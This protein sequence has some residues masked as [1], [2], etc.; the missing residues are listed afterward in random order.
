MQRRINIGFV[1]TTVN[2]G[3]QER[4]LVKIL[5]RLDKERF[6][7]Y[8]YCI[9]QP[10]HLAEDIRS[11]GAELVGP[12]SMCK[13]DLLVPWR[14]AARF[15]HDKI[16]VVN[17][18]G[19]GD[20]MF[21]GRLA[22]KIAGVPVIVAA[23]HST[24]D[25]GRGKVISGPNR[26]LTPITDH[27]IGVGE[28]Q[29]RYLAEH[30]GLPKDRTQVI[31]NGVDHNIFAPSE[32]D[33]MRIRKELN[34]APNAPVIGVVAVMRP[35]KAHGI[36]LKAMQSITA[37]FPD[38]VLFFIGDG[39]ERPNIEKSIDEMGLQRSV[40]LLG[41][42]GD[43]PA[44]L[45][46]LDVA[47]LCSDT[48]AFSNAILEYMAVGKPVVATRVGSVEEMVEEDSTAF[49]IPTQDPDKL[50]EAVIRLL[51]DPDKAREMGRLGRERVINCFSIENMA[52]AREKLFETLLKEKGKLPKSH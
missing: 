4:G 41:L 37:K 11:N 28:K 50:A 34:V 22:G 18:I 19:Q 46:A 8:V 14:L 3:G 52:R 49:L 51:D 17:T 20:A 31:Y 30:E 27:F 7:P 32:A 47:V 26:L 25:E 5:S 43:I 40:Q 33:R 29:T 13:T 44:V 16:D 23:V 48:E 10:G 24:T 6:C 45:N 9:K 38:T 12:V 36:M 39:P 15:R 2:V 42:R 21:W 1:L 35:E